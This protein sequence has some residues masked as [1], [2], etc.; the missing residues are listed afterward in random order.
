MNPWPAAKV[1][2]LRWMH[3]ALLCSEVD[4]RLDD[5][6]DGKLDPGDRKRFE[7][8]MRFCRP[9]RDYLKA[10]ERTIALTRDVTKIEPADEPRLPDAVIQSI[11]ARQRD[12]RG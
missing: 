2:L 7:R 12:E 3:G 9:C 6:H 10:Y 1:W 11:L 5:Y 4:K 8:H